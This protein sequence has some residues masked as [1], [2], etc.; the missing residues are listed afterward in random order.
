[1][2]P[3]RRPVKTA[4]VE[5]RTRC[6][7]TAFATVRHSIE[8]GVET[9]RSKDVVLYS[10][11]AVCYLDKPWLSSKALTN[12]VSITHFPRRGGR[13]RA[14]GGRRAGDSGRCFRRR[15][16]A[17]RPRRGSAPGNRVGRIRRALSRAVT[18]RPCEI[19]STKPAWKGYRSWPVR[20]L[21]R[22]A[23]RHSPARGPALPAVLPA[24]RNA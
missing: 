22:M 16:R 19:P 11:P 2:L 5:L 23:T 20:R 21:G 18:R 13:R 7:N 10:P 12:F 6:F 9:P 17:R 15:V 4:S 8:R 14:G 24:R 1:M 3:P